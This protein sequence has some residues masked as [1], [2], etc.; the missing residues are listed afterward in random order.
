MVL[1]GDLVIDVLFALFLL[2]FL[3]TRLELSDK[4]PCEARIEA[5]EKQV[6]LLCDR[7]VAVETDLI[8]R[9]YTSVVNNNSGTHRTVVRPVA[10]LCSGGA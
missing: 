6:Q 9:A 10:R 5:L 2:V 1:F 8:T 4:S 3:V 7:L